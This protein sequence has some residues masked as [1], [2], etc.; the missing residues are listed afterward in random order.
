MQRYPLEIFL[1]LFGGFDESE[2]GDLDL[3]DRADLSGI[4]SV[5]FSSKTSKPQKNK[6][7]N[8]TA[9]TKYTKTT[10]DDMMR[11]KQKKRKQWMSIVCLTQY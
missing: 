4:K 2:S 1:S 8:K 11:V 5:S 6:F 3:I 9:A 7:K 10:L